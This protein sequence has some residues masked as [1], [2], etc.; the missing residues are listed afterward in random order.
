MAR[1]PDCSCSSSSATRSSFDAALVIAL[2]VAGLSGLTWLGLSG[3]RRPGLTAAFAV[4]C[5]LPVLVSAAVAFYA[6]IQPAVIGN[7]AGGHG[8]LAAGAAGAAGGAEG[9]GVQPISVAD[10]RTPAE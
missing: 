7:T 5:V 3:R 9:S 6:D 4:L 10:L 1:P 8:H 2:L